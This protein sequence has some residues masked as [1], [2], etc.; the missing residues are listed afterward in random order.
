[1]FYIKSGNSMKKVILI[2]MGIIGLAIAACKK[3]DNGKKATSVELLTSSTWIYD[4]VTLDLNKDG[5]PDSAVPSGFI[6]SCD[7][8]DSL[9]FKS[10]G[11]GVTNEGLTK[12]DDSLPQTS[13]FAW[14]LSNNDST[15]TITGTS[16]ANLNGDATIQTLTN[17]KLVLV[18]HVVINDVITLDANVIVA[19]KK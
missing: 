13:P 12:C 9:T 16:Q 7:L 2:A 18:K 5:I 10:D 4:T 15:I 19:L 6:S 17:T 11:T 8:D 1:M 14:A 3:S